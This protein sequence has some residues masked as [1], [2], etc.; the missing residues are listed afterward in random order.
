MAFWMEGTGTSRYNFKS[1]LNN[2]LYLQSIFVQR[3]THE[4]CVRTEFL[5]V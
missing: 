4:T 5:F 1:I 3:R 2:I